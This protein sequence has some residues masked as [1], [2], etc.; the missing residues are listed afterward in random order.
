MQP[1]DVL[2]HEPFNIPTL[3]QS[4]ERT[5][6]G[7]GR[8]VPEALPTHETAR[9]VAPPR[10]RLAHE[11]LQS[12]GLRALPAA[13]GIAIVGNAGIGAAACTGENE[14]AGIALDEIGKG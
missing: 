3:L 13:V 9:P 10:A 12:D 7:I 11:R 4:G 1:I 8:S 5:M 2:R 6:C 14:E